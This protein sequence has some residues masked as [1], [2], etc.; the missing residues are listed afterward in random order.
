MLYPCDQF[1]FRLAISPNYFSRREWPHSGAGLRVRTFQHKGG[2]K[3]T[4]VP[5][6]SYI[7]N[8]SILFCDLNM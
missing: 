5:I 2:A 1:S 8:I 4:A 7:C 6:S 3:P